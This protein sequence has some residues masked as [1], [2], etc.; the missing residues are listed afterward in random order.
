MGLV[1]KGE[2]LPVRRRNG[3]DKFVAAST[4]S[5]SGGRTTTGSRQ[6]VQHL[7]ETRS[8]TARTFT[9]CSGTTAPR[10]HGCRFS[11]KRRQR[12]PDLLAYVNDAGATAAP[13]VQS[14]RPL[15]S[16]TLERSEGLASSRIPSGAAGRADV[17]S[18]RRRQ[19][20]HERRL[21]RYVAGQHGA[22]GCG[23]G[24]AAGRRVSAGSIKG[25]TSTPGAVR[26]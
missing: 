25:R 12:H 9:R 6:P 19:M 5:R 10:H 14:R 22:R 3:L 8:S 17:G 16:E 2:L 24:L 15:R 7:R 11:S 4:T 21:A 20:E 18:A 26:T 13:L 23:V 1:R